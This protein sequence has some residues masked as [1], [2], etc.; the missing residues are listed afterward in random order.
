MSDNKDLNREWWD[1]RYVDD[2]IPWDRQ[3]V[4]PALYHWLE[5]GT[6]IPGR[7]LVPGCGRGHE[8]LELTRCGFDVT[9]L[10]IS[11]TAIAFLRQRLG[12]QRLH[13]D[14]QQVDLF[15]W[16]PDG[17]Y[18]AIYDQTGLC[19]MVPSQW[20][21]YERR[22]HRWLHSDGHLIWEQQLSG[23]LHYLPHITNGVVLV[24]TNQAELAAY[25]ARTGKRLWH[26]K[27]N[28]ELI[29]GPVMINNKII[30]FTNKKDVLSWPAS[31]LGN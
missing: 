3:G 30:S 24:G 14:V 23:R 6:L 2:H 19:A 18:D 8:V 9:A 17:A 20:P 27:D 25:D 26:H 5:A 28:H 11:P 22:L 10:D 16:E 15:A 21:D 29:A 13:A 7:I 31:F 1:N 4:S 12:E